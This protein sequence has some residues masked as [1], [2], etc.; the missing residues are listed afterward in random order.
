MDE[1]WGDEANLCGDIAVPEPTEEPEDLGPTQTPDA[2]DNFFNEPVEQDLEKELQNVAGLAGVDVSALLQDDIVVPNLVAN[3]VEDEAPPG[4]DILENL[5]IQLPLDPVAPT[6]PPTTQPP[7]FMV[8]FSVLEVEEEEEE[9]EEFEE[10]DTTPPVCRPA[11]G[12][13][14]PITIYMFSNDFKDPGASCVDDGQ[15][16]PVI[17][18]T[19]VQ[20]RDADGTWKNGKI[21][22]SL[23]VEMEYRMI[24]RN[25][26]AAGNISPD[27]VRQVR[28]MDMHMRMKHPLFTPC[29]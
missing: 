22:S 3:A 4:P 18:A 7:K 15:L 21:E 26:D 29:A 12:N 17:M 9:E 1:I 24:Y 2:F 11:D 16:M 6:P 25:T 13:E 28:E 19:T 10:P 8:D 14:A 23:G 5:N 27:L 20:F